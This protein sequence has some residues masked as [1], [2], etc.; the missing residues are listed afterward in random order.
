MITKIFKKMINNIKMKKRNNKIL[1]FGLFPNIFNCLDET[2]NKESKIRFCNYLKKY[3]D[4][5]KWS[6][7]SDY[8]LDDKNKNSNVYTFALFP[9]TKDISELKEEVVQNIKSEIK[10]SGNFIPESTLNYLNNN[11]FF[12]FNFVFPKDFLKNY[13]SKNFNKESEIS[14]IEE[15]IKII[16]NNW[17]NDYKDVVVNSLNNLIKKMKERNF[18]LSL[19]KKILL[20]SF[21][22]AYLCTFLQRQKNIET[23]SWLSDRDNMTTYGSGIINAL[24]LWRKE[25]IKKIIKIKFSPIEEGITILESKTKPFYDELIRV[26]DYFCGTLASLIKFSKNKDK[27]IEFSKKY[28]QIIMNVLNSNKNIVTILFEDS[29]LYNKNIIEINC[30]RIDFDSIYII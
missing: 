21:L 30:H 6:I 28:D 2:M 11:D 16:K 26:P 29:E 22:A 15:Q 20:N 3:K 7:C 12:I 19:Y 14:S 23:Y 4:I 17:K 10:K 27:Y 8:C 25:E 5:K 13:F 1:K 24:Y 9:V 18:N